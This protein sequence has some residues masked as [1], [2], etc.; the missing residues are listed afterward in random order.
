MRCIIAPSTQ[1][2]KNAL[3]VH[4]TAPLFAWDA[5]EDSPSLRT[6]RRFLAN[7]P[8]GRLLESLRRWRGRGM[9]DYPVHVL[10]GVVLLTIALRHQAVRAPLQGTHRRGTGQCPFQT[11]LGRRRRQHHRLPP[12]PRV[13]RRGHGRACSLRHT[14][15]RHSQAFRS[16]GAN[17]PGAHP[18]SPPAGDQP[19]TPNRVTRK[20]QGRSGNSA[21]TPPQASFPHFHSLLMPQCMPR[22]P[23]HA[24]ARRILLDQP[25]RVRAPATDH[26]ATG[27][28][29]LR[30]GGRRAGRDERG[31]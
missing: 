22:T 19:L 14:P 3:Y 15:G 31:R 10:W 4:T 9:D 30:D 7:I 1:E 12:L 23:C 11:V 24:A 25:R 5:L 26:S 18:E 6:L 8:D 21:R 2:K 13:H 17:A 16:Y 27:S 20:Q 29:S 28:L